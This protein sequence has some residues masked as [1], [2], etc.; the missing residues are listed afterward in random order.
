MNIPYFAQNKTKKQKNMSTIMIQSCLF[1]NLCIFYVK[2][3]DGQ[4]TALSILQLSQPGL[5]PCASFSIA[6]GPRW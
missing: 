4:Y 5:R 6:S 1:C 2:F 3:L